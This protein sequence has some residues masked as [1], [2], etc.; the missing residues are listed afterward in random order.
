MKVKS[1]LG[2]IITSCCLL[3]F[4]GCPN[5]FSPDLNTGKDNDTNFHVQEA[6]QGTGY[7]LLTIECSEAARTILPTLPSKESLY[8]DLLFYP[9]DG[10][11]PEPFDR[12]NY[13]ALS[14]PVILPVGDYQLYVKAYLNA[15]DTDPTFTGAFEDETGEP[16][17]ISIS[18]NQ[19][20]TGEVILNSFISEGTGTFSWD[21]TNA[22]INEVSYNIDIIPLSG[23]TTI[24]RTEQ[25][26]NVELD[27]GYYRVITTLTLSA[28]EDSKTAVRSDILHIRKNLTS[29]FEPSF[30]AS[31]FFGTLTGVTA[32]LSMTFPLIGE[33]MTATFSGNSGDGFIY[34]WRNGNLFINNPTSSPV[35]EP[36]TYTVTVRRTGY[37]GSVTSQPLEVIA[38]LG[39]GTDI[40]PYEIENKIQLE[41]L[42]K[43]T[44]EG[45]TDYNAAGLHYKLANDIDLTSITN[46]TRIGGTTETNG[47]KGTFDGN[48]KTITGL[49]INRPTTGN[50]G[51]FGFISS[52]GVVRNLSLVDVSITGGSNTGAV[53][54]ENAGVIERVFASGT[55]SGPNYVGGITGRSR[56]NADNSNIG[57]IRNVAS[58]VNVSGNSTLVGGIAGSLHPGGT[59]INAYSTGR[60]QGVNTVSGIAPSGTISTQIDKS[61]IQNSV[62]LNSAILRTS[63]SLTYFTRISVSNVNRVNNYGRDDVSIS[64]PVAIESGLGLKDGETITDEW[65]DP[66]WW[67]DFV[68]LE[69][70]DEDWEW[71]RDKLPQ[72]LPP[73][74]GSE[75][76]PIIIT[77]EAQLRQVGSGNMGMSLAA[78]YTMEAN[79]PTLTGGDWVPIGTNSNHFIGTFNGNNHTIAGLNIK[80]MQDNMPQGLFVQIGTSGIVQNL[81]LIDV[82]ITSSG[83]ATGAIAGI[84]NGTITQSFASGTINGQENTGGITGVN[85]SAGYVGVIDTCYFI[86][87]VS[88]GEHVG[89]IAGDNGHNNTGSP[90]SSITNSVALATNIQGNMDENSRISG[91][92]HLGTLTNNY[93][94]AGM[95]VNGNLVTTDKGL[96]TVHGED[97]T[98]AN[99]EAVQTQLNSAF[100]VNA[101]DLQ[102]L[103]L[104]EFIKQMINNL[105]SEGG[106]ITLTGSGSIGSTMTVDKDVIITTPPGQTVTITRSSEMTPADAIF[107]IPSG[108]TLTL[109]AGAGGELIIE[110][111]AIVTQMRQHIFI[112]PGG[113][114]VMGDG[115]KITNLASTNSG[116]N[117]SGI[118]VQGN[119]EVKG[120]F[121]MTGGEISR[122]GRHG[123]VLVQGGIFNMSGGKISGCFGNNNSFGG[124]VTITSNIINNITTVG[125]FTMSGG[126]ISGNSSGSGLGGG[127]VRVISGTF[128][129][130]GGTIRNNFA[131]AISFGG[132]VAVASGATFNKTGGTIYGVDAEAEDRNRITNNPNPFDRFLGQGYAVYCE[133]EHKVRDNTAYAEDNL[134]SATV[135][136]A[137]GWN[138]VLTSTG[139]TVS[140]SGTPQVGQTLTAV[141]TP[142]GTSEIL[143]MWRRDTTNTVYQISDSP[144][145][146][147][148]SQQTGSL[149]VSVFRR[150][151][152]GRI[153][154]AA[155]NVIAATPP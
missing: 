91:R 41:Y 84:N 147:P 72:S 49:T 81:G 8:F 119:S 55:V 89:A 77:T 150:D 117:F 54:G 39:A 103:Y 40:A 90:L 32:S 85:G 80:P 96:E 74:V 9:K 92:N 148:T 61:T 60:V 149:T 3:L 111:T 134:H 1:L 69:I 30:A 33:T 70:S 141:I 139:I 86:G 122:L 29:S 88:G 129:M 97:I 142:D 140:I 68:F 83:W 27:S 118:I 106:T 38:F 101:P 62:A 26:G 15:S 63:G 120:I 75:D 7:F 13:Q 153:T 22:G 130:E 104:S 57:I 98:T 116:A 11:D 128:N 31:N 66:E 45:D 12:C 5:L 4:S 10:G 58:E 52:T 6:V 114:L 44:N 138:P 59:V 112:E 115:V 105:P 79:I 21:I 123:G 107:N 71:W 94:F 64:M 133:N 35:L 76:A 154:S 18:Y 152:S 87:T 78:H 47:F 93:A 20:V 144:T 2:F 100:G 73:A 17:I 43:R 131:G 25:S 132:G 28:G 50:Q 136:E 82:N 143:Y 124:G 53:A 137:G 145:F 146:V 126:E 113:K 121:E 151:N 36:G 24:N 102:S 51:M 16:E 56:G 37:N 14:N 23:G 46:W 125:S 109:A 65:L 42:A 34:Q 108:G 19:T 135:G 127:G 110:S 99:V 155:V 67:Y 48:G 95:L